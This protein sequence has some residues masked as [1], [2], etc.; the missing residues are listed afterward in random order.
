[1]SS[2]TACILTYNEENKIANAVNS[3]IAWADEVVVID[4]FSTD[5]TR[6]VA[7]SLGASVVD[8]AFTSFGEL[9]NEALKHCNH[10]WVFSLDADERCTPEA[11][12]EITV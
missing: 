9:R 12:A 5:N 11:Q 2:V 7:E 4:S 6:A 1:M 10:P 3:V 8:V